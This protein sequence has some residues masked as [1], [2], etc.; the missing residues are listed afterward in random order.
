MTDDKFGISRIDLYGQESIPE[1][2]IKDLAEIYTIL[3]NKYYEDEKN[4]KA[5]KAY[6]YNKVRR[7][8]YKRKKVPNN[9]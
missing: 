3:I 6:S 5:F 7:A 9:P 8:R 2:I 4:V 1:S